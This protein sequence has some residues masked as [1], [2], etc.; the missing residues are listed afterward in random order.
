M[1]LASMALFSACSLEEMPENPGATDELKTITVPLSMSGTQTR[2]AVDGDVSSSDESWKFNWENEEH[3]G[4]W[5]SGCTSLADFEM[6]EYDA[7]LST[8][9]GSVSTG[10]ESIRVVSPY[11]ASSATISGN[12]CSINI[13]AQDGDLGKLYMISDELIDVNGES[14]TAAPKMKHIG[15]FFALDFKLKNE[16]SGTNY[17]ITKVELSGVPTTMDVDLTGDYDNYTNQNSN[18]K[19]TATLAGKSFATTDDIV[20]VRLNTLP[21]DFE[22]NAEMTF[23]ITYKA[24]EAEHTTIAVLKNS[25]ENAIP[26]ERAKYNYVTITIDPTAIS[27]TAK[28][29][30]WGPGNDGEEE[31]LDAL[32]PEPAEALDIELKD[33]VY[34]IY[35]AEGFEAFASIVNTAVTDISGLTTKG[36]SNNQVARNTAANGKLMNDIDLSSVCGSSSK[37]WTPIGTGTSTYV[38]AGVFDGAYFTISGLYINSS[39]SNYQALFGS[40]SG[41]GAMVK[42]LAIDGGSVKGSEYVGSV[43]G[44]V[45]AG[46]CVINCSNS[47]SVICYSRGGGIAG[48]LSTGG[49]AIN[50]YNSGTVTSRSSTISTGGVVGRTYTA[51]SKNYITNCYNS[52]SVK[53]ALK[54][55]VGGV[56]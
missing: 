48:Q 28:I 53:N 7:N 39:N 1:I 51:S 3:V 4:V 25:S 56:V 38:Y 27:S 55:S 14:V 8:F 32:L 37:S 49:S 11:D 34:E 2:I 17:E 31:D 20:K 29:D 33:G 35:T 16:T 5:Y 13:S 54:Y 40:V 52:G 23:T 46:A 6:D 45:R 30:V 15:G 47:A 24:G 12:T 21:F 18:R 36:F 41:A 22:P 44:I 10:T 50:C 43:A 9:T 42:N 26:F 19:I